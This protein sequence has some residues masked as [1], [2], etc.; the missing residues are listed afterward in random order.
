[1]M[2]NEGHYISLN[3]KE[4]IME[5]PQLGAAERL[6]RLYL[7]SAEVQSIL[8]KGAPK[9]SIL[10]MLSMLLVDGTEYLSLL[11]KTY[12]GAKAASQAGLS[13][14]NFFMYGPVCESA[15]RFLSLTKE[16]GARLRMSSI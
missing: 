8:V 11:L 10:A 12:A 5:R 15:R 13:T 3:L 7:G 14:E 4:L 16:K 9:S 6:S 2:Y 1:M